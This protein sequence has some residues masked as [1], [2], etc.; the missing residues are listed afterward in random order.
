MAHR[1]RHLAQTVCDMLGNGVTQYRVNGSHVRHALVQTTLLS[2]Y[3][4]GC[5]C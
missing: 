1:D 4:F 3:N 5:Q 2:G